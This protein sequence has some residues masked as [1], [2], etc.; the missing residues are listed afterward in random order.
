MARIGRTYP[1]F[2]PA[3][4]ENPVQEP[5][6]GRR[7]GDA[8]SRVSRSQIAGAL[9]GLAAALGFIGFLLSR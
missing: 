9:V 8:R 6:A 3:G 7:S 1:R 5:R 2:P 4:E